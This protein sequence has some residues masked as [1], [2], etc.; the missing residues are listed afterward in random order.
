MPDDKVFS[1][2]E[3]IRLQRLS[4]VAGAQ[5]APHAEWDLETREKRRQRWT[6]VAAERYPLPKVERPRVVRDRTDSE[7]SWRI[8]GGVLQFRVGVAEWHVMHGHAGG[9]SRFGT[10]FTV[11][12]ERVAIW[13]DLLANPTELVDADV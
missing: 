1:E 10:D 12:L 13:A 5:A 8:A 6:V 9:N 7:V 3:T 4:F 2:R 11:S